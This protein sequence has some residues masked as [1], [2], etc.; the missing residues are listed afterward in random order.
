MRFTV[1][2]ASCHVDPIA[3]LPNRDDADQ[4]VRRHHGLQGHTAAVTEVLETP[5][6]GLL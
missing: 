4:V 2:C 1:S 6:E 3:D 5:L